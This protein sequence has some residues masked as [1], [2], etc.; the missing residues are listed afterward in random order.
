MQLIWFGNPA[1]E[2]PDAGTWK[3]GY[4]GTTEEMCHYRVSTQFDIIERRRMP[5]WLEVESRVAVTAQD[6]GKPEKGGRVGL[7]GGGPQGGK[8][9]LALPPRGGE[10]TRD[11]SQN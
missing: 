6:P 2:L 4:Y 9:A 5:T 11:V 3:G 8:R 10:K 1:E 7:P